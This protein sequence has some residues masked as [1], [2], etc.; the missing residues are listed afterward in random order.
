MSEV[1]GALHF[2][3][4]EANRSFP[5]KAPDNKSENRYDKLEVNVH[6]PDRG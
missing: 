1:K 3:G 5:E 2:A 6:R 4:T